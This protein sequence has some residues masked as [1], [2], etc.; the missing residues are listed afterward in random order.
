MRQRSL[1]ISACGLF[2]LHV[3]CSD[4]SSSN[5]DAATG[6]GGS[7]TG[8]TKASATGG[9]M[10]TG[11]SVGTGA[12]GGGLGGGGKAGRRCLAHA[13]GL[14]HASQIQNVLERLGAG[15][16]ARLGQQQQGSGV[17]VHGFLVLALVPEV[18]G[19]GIEVGECGHRQ[20]GNHRH[21]RPVHEPVTAP[22]AAIRDLAH[23]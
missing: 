16:N 9:T 3:A 8:G 11:G 23:V 4:S 6:A 17:H 5:S 2:I 10:A 21:R 14:E 7:A 15:I 22:R 1:F 20:P 19:G 18:P 12:G 13:V